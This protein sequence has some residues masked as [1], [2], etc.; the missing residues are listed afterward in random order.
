[1]SVYSIDF[2]GTLCENAWPEIGV[3]K[4]DVINF[5]KARKAEGDKLILSTC[6]EGDLLKQAIAWCAKH[7]LHFDTHNENLPELIKLYGGDS[8]KISADY[9]IDDKN[10]DI[11]KLK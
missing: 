2:D 7:G 8:R 10:L 11:S 5:C 9:Y 6:R 1:M 3:P 4:A